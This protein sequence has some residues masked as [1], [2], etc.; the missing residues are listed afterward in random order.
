MQMKKSKAFLAAFLAVASTCTTIMPT[1]ASAAVANGEDPDGRTKAEAYGDETYAQRF[2]SLYD[3]VIT[4]GVENGYMSSTS[5]VSGGLGVPYHSAEELCIEA[6]DYGHETTSEA[7]SYL[8][9]VAAMRDNIVN[10]AKSG[11]V[12]VK[13]EKD[14]STEE[15]GDTAKAW[16]TMEAT[17]VPDAQ[18]RIMTLGD[19]LS[20]TYSD[21]WEQIEMYPTGMD[22]NVKGVNPIH[23]L[24]CNA[25]GSDQGLYLMNWLADVDD[26][27]GFGSGVGQY[28]QKNVS[29]N[30]TLI[31]SFQRGEQE[32]CW[33]TIPHASVET[34]SLFL[35]T[36]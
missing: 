35:E 36:V 9:W 1:V 15:V 30:F 11:E 33:E 2:M 5:T 27:Y 25:Y 3:D 29:G 6:P 32:S 7:M 12:T 31:N 21:E 26:W 4:N 20:A 17:L 23:S 34:L 24:F 28:K 22:S 8:V 10:A 16:K 18:G 14:A 13:G 19:Q